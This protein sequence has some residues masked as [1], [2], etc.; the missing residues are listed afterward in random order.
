MGQCFSSEGLVT[1]KKASKSEAK[2]KVH[3]DDDILDRIITEHLEE[4]DNNNAFIPDFVEKGIYK[5]VLK[6]LLNIMATGLRSVEIQVLGH[7]IDIK[8]RPIVEESVHTS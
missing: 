3:I 4:K 1:T 2:S 8:L 5:N 7:V 6:L